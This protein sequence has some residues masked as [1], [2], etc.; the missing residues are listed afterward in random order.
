MRQR[1]LLSV[2]PLA[3]SFL[4]T[5][6]TKSYQILEHVIAEVAPRLNLMDLQIF[7]SPAELASP[8]VPLQNFTAE[9]A[10][11]VILE[12][13]AWPLGSNSNQGTT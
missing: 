12:L 4:V 3:M 5:H 1:V 8:A 10:I 9:L 6:N 7:C 11:S 2:L 13:Q